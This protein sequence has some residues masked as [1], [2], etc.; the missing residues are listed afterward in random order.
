MAQTQTKAP[1]VSASAKMA[2]QFMAFLLRHNWMGPAGNELLVIT[3]TGRKSGKRYSTPI[4]YLRDGETVI[5]LTHAATPSNWYRNAL[6]SGQ[7]WLE[8][9]GQLLK[10]RVEPVSDQAKRD[11][12]FELYQQARARSFSRYF[13][14]SADAPEAELTQA[15]TMRDFVKMTAVS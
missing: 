1:K 13:D 8:I 12:I 6:S 2:M 10:V 5:A 15:L 14:V 9:K 3:T 4:G 7:A 11:R